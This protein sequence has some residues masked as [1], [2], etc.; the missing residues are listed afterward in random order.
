MGKGIDVGTG[1]ATGPWPPHFSSK[2]ILKIFPFF[3]KHIF[4]TEN[5]APGRG[6]HKS[7]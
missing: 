1:G 5:D 4:H 3:L 2:I 7:A 6:K